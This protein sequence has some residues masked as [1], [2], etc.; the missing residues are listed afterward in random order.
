M[1]STKKAAVCPYCNEAYIV[2]EAIN[3]YVTNIE[4]LHADVVNISDDRAAKGRLEAAEAFLKLKDWANANKAFQEACNLTPQNYQGWWGRIRALSQ[5]FT[6]DLFLDPDVKELKNL[7]DSAV[8]FV[9]KEREAGIRSVFDAYFTP[10]YNKN[11]SYHRIVDDRLQKL[12]KKEE[13]LRTE[14]E[15]WRSADP[16]DELS[17]FDIHHEWLGLLTVIM[18]IWGVIR[19]FVKR[20]PVA[21]VLIA[22]PLIIYILVGIH[23]ISV[24]RRR[25]ERN[26]ALSAIESKMKDVGD[27]ESEYRRVSVL[28]S[29]EYMSRYEREQAMRSF[30]RIVGNAAQNGN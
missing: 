10:L 4:N 12:T 2:E 1:D 21:L 15:A 20:D 24:K 18:L 7:F 23:N 6:A 9:P 19:Y 22:V 5:E 3:S 13:K 16:G 17:L 29:G 14:N 28:L 11:Q 26:A 25:S 27:E 30:D 8:M